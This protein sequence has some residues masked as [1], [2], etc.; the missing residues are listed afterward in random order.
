MNF[1]FALVT[2]S[3]II[4]ASLVRQ[5]ILSYLIQIYGTRPGASFSFSSLPEVPIRL[6]AS[7]I[8]WSLPPLILQ[9][10]RPK[11]F[12]NRFRFL[13]SSFS[14]NFSRM[15]LACNLKVVITPI[16]PTQ[17]PSC[18]AA[19]RS[20]QHLA[21]QSFLQE[22]GFL[23]NFVPLA[24]VR[25][26]L[27]VPITLVA[28]V[29]TDE[30]ATDIARNRLI[31][32]C[33]DIWRTNEILSPQ[34]G[35]IDEVL[36]SPCSRRMFR[37]SYVPRHEPGLTSPETLDSKFSA[38]RFWLLAQTVYKHLN[39]SNLCKSIALWASVSMF[40]TVLKTLK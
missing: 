3:M 18:T 23:G 29:R 25:D 35:S 32:G 20:A 12:S 28:Q 24:C 33:S 27:N 11:R 37:H 5:I 16:W 39:E 2:V 19:I 13:A 15:S 36:Y 34:I 30:I 22:L 8:I 17:G 9:H 1:D 31:S 26:F 10:F 6:V 14:S 21:S 7:L 40:M 4:T 38:L